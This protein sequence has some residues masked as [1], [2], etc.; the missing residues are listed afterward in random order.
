MSPDR[1]I[2]LLRQRFGAVEQTA[3]HLFRAERR[4]QNSPLGV[5]YFDFSD[6]IL[7]PDFD[8]QR[9]SHEHIA[10]DFYRHEGSVQWNYYLYFV[11]EPETYAAVP[12]GRIAK[13]EADR[14]YTRKFVREQKALELELSRSLPDILRSTRPPQDLA[15][16]WSEKL[17]AAGLG[18][19]ANPLAPYVPTVAQY[20]AHGAPAA[21][22]APPKPASAAENGRFIRTLDLERFRPHPALRHFEF[23]TV[24][25]I[26]GV[27]GTGKTSLLE[28]IELAVCGGIRRQEGT[29]PENVLLK[30]HYQGAARAE[31]AP[32]ANAAAYRARDLT[33]Y[34]GYRRAGNDMCRSFARFNFFD[35]DA[36]FRLSAAG[37]PAEMLKALDSLLLGEVATAIEERMQQFHERF[38][39]QEA[40]LGKQRRL[41]ETE[42]RKAVEQLQEL[43]KIRDT[44]EVL[45]K[46][47]AAKGDNAGWGKLPAP[48]TVQNLAALQESVEE[49]VTELEQYQK[50][51]PWLGKISIATL[52]QYARALEKAGEQLA[53]QRKEARINQVDDEKTTL[54]LS[55]IQKKHELLAR[56]D[57]YHRQPE[58]IKLIDTSLALE[59]A[60][61][62][63]TAYKEA[64]TTLRGVDLNKFRDQ[65]QPV[66][67]L[68]EL[69]SAALGKSRRAVAKLRAQ[70][71][72]VQGQLGELQSVVQEIRGLGQRYCELSV[73]GQECPLC[74]TTHESLANR[75]K[76]TRV[77]SVM[78][79][80]LRELTKQISRAEGEAQQLIRTD[81]E[82]QKVRDAADLVIDDERVA[83]RSM[84]GLI[85]V[86][87]GLEDRQAVGRARVDTLL[88]QQK[89]LRMAGF[90]EEE[91]GEL[92]EELESKHSWPSS[93]LEKPEAV[94]ALLADT[95]KATDLLRD[96][97]RD[98]QKTRKDIEA[99]ILRITRAID[100]TIDPNDAEIEFERRDYLVA[101]ALKSLHAIRKKVTLSDQ[102]ETT[103]AELRL[104][105]FAQAIARVQI[106]LKR[107]EERDAIEQKTQETFKRAS[108]ELE[109]LVPRHDRARKAVTVLTSLLG[110]TY[111]GAFTR[112]V[113]RDH[114]EKLSAIFTQMH[115]PREFRDTHFQEQI[116]LERDSGALAG[117]AEI[118]TGQRTALALSI[119]L[120][121][122]SSVSDRAPWLI[123]DDPVVHVDDL[124]TLSFMD[125]L[126]DLVLLGHRQLF[127]AT[128][129][130]RIADLFTRKF[131]C[132][133]NEFKSIALT[134]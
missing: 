114:K 17:V 65:P 96:K 50:R 110:E 122:N 123:F 59:T 108:T 126:R 44:R 55:E 100:A 51:L 43:A 90:T 106:A 112:Q 129:N 12:A 127:F 10:S 75:I 95:K 128:A 131:D 74:G 102:D 48:I 72:G 22:A 1:T 99:A 37:D 67:A 79:T 87:S 115:A 33:W 2:T 15:S 32:L 42:Q 68:L 53:I 7:A 36:A 9:Y 61:K 85:E 82:L 23:G 92:L 125:M 20:L 103:G 16:I 3:E 5:F 11:L 18:A 80:A 77:A 45:T 86:L 58:A 8:L 34:G 46:E 13:I 83:A 25:L 97:S 120:S 29:R 118:S 31:T 39:Q 26:R 66:A 81:I 21:P 117:V 116:R 6:R 124:N 73:S 101:N 94:K 56:L 98:L 130:S 47:L 70:A 78:E 24:N 28:A 63:M 113:M 64:A 38:T 88:A 89:R 76:E 14:I 71:T 84:K 52:S 41:N 54:Q 107:I 121:L 105:A 109:T 57:A 134:R 4:K 49:I 19:V 132:F 62:H 69:N 35:S 40:S 104:D 133:G 60:R 93:R 111:K 119:F 30:V 27:N 91:L